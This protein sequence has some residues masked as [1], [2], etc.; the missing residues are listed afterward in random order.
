MRTFDASSGDLRLDASGNVAM[1]D[2]AAAAEQII[3][4]LALAERGEMVFRARQGM[5]FFATTLGVTNDVA[6][7]EAAFRRRVRDASYLAADVTRFDAQ[8]SGALFEY[9]ATIKTAYGEVTVSG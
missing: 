3:A 2:D 4:A 8:Q 9:R 6:Q 7:F 1:V 5:P